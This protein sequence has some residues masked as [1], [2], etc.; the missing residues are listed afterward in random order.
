MIER[1]QF[2][3]NRFKKDILEGDGKRLEKHLTMASDARRGL[4]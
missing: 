1:Y 2:S 3:L 4:G